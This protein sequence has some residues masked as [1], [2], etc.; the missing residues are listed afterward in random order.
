VRLRWEAVLFCRLRLT[1]P[2]TGGRMGAGEETPCKDAVGRVPAT[3]VKLRAL[4]LDAVRWCRRLVVK[5]CEKPEVEVR[6]WDDGSATWVDSVPDALA[7]V[8]EALDTTEAF[9]A[10]RRSES[11]RV[12]RLTWRITG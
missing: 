3:A 4:V 10:A 7:D 8:E 6:C 1:L 11:S 12:R 9:C 5:G 2:T